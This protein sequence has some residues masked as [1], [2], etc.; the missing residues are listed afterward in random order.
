ME[1]W[2]H[3]VNSKN[4]ILVRLQSKALRIVLNCKRSEDAWKHNNNRIAPLKT[5][6]ESV[7][8]RLCLKQHANMLPNHFSNNIM[9]EFNL[10]QLQNKITRTSLNQMYDYKTA[11]PTNST[12][13]KTNCI[14]IWNSLS[15]EFKS[16]P[17]VSNKT[18]TYKTL[19]SLSH[20][21]SVK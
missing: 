12:N 2:G 8:K 18:A 15:L 14:K 20:S 4:D 16:T 17:Y 13:F 10:S 19:S 11:K 21:F 9:P 3:T 1:V 6:Y 7:I 5:L